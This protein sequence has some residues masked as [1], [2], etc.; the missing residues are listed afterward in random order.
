MKPTGINVARRPEFI[1]LLKKR[2]NICVRLRLCWRGI[3]A[4]YR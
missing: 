1:L 3:N 2:S 4:T